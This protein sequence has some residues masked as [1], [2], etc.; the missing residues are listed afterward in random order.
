M[1]GFRFF[2]H[3][4]GFYMTLPPDFKVTSHMLWMGALIFAL[5]DAGF[6]PLLAWRIQPVTFRQVK[7]ILVTT[8]AIFWSGLWTWALVN[9]WDSVYR[10]VFP[11]WAR[12]LIPPAYGLL[13][14]GVG[15]L[16]WW[17]ALR[18][19]GNPVLGFCLLGGLWGMITHLWAVFLGIVDKPP[20]LQ[21]ATP[22]GAVIMAVFEFIFYGCMI[23]GVAALL[24]SAR[25]W[26]KGL[27]PRLT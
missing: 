26:F 18:M 8:T 27:A 7:W 10:Y 9:F 1:P 22:A 20:M 4:L 12:W 2:T 16:S 19:P 14:A 24:D 25:R 11:A 6:V 3:D 15:L 21:G 17:L 23:L 5:I 13:F